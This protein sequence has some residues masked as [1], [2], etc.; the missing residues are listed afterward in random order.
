[1]KKK[2]IARRVVG[3]TRRAGSE[4]AQTRIDQHF[5]SGPRRSH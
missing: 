2:K 5:D 3:E 4:R 1:M